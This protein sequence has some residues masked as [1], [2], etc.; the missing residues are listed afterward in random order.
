[1]SLDRILLNLKVLAQLPKHGRLCKGDQG[2]IALEQDTFYVSFKRFLFQES[3]RQ[4][5]REI[6]IIVDNASDKVSDLVSSRFLNRDMDKSEQHRM[7]VEDLGQLLTNIELAS[8][9]VENM[10]LTTYS[11]D[12]TTRSELDLLTLK[13]FSTVR[14]IKRTVE[15]ITLKE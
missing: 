3:R 6:K 12:A 15:R 7:V 13:M 14:L 10:K 8:Q 5:L 1:M 11:K 4:T 2:L 9:G